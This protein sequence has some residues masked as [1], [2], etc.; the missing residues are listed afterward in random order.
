MKVAELAFFS[1]LDLD[2]L[3]SPQRIDVKV[4]SEKMEQHQEQ[5]RKQEIPRQ[6]LQYCLRGHTL[7]VSATCSEQKWRFY[8]TSP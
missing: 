6:D 7:L 8:L 5:T 3:K 2:V 1:H 4:K